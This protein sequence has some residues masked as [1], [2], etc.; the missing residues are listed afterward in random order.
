ML[1]R[2][3]ILLLKLFKTILLL[4]KPKGFVWCKEKGNFLL[5]EEEDL[6]EL[7]LLLLILIILKK[8]FSSFL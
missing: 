3:F 8:L 2:L 6:D 5:I 7:S 1:F 4:I